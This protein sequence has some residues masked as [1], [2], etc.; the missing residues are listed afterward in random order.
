MTTRGAARTTH[1]VVVAHG[2][3]PRHRVAPSPALGSAGGTGGT[4]GRPRVTPAIVAG[5]EHVMTLARVAIT[6]AAAARGHSLVID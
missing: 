3:R 5:T 6:V 4:A 1:T 2:V